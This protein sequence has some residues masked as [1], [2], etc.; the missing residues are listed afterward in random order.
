MPLHGTLLW[1]GTAAWLVPAGSS[2]AAGA[3]VRVSLWGKRRG[4]LSAGPV[5]LGH[6]KLL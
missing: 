5:A 4:L 6:A 3:G 2:V 1:C